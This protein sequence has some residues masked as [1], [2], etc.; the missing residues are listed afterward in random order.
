MKF[1]KGFIFG[2]ALSAGIMMIYNETTKNGKNTV[3]KKG[4]KI[5]K[6]M[7]MM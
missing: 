1:I 5:M 7:G 4:R 6:N 2:T 3:M